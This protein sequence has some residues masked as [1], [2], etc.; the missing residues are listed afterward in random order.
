MDIEGRLYSVAEETISSVLLFISLNW[1][2]NSEPHAHYMS[3][4]A[5]ESRP[6]CF[7]HPLAF[8]LFLIQESEKLLPGFAWNSHPLDFYPARDC[9]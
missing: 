3:T 1:E 6:Q 2:L 9:R 7:S 5:L 4:L 8:S